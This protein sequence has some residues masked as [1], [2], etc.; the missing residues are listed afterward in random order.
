[1]KPDVELV[2]RLNY[3]VSIDKN[4]VTVNIKTSPLSDILIGYMSDCLLEKF[5]DLGT[6]VYDHT[7]LKSQDHVSIL[8]SDNP[9]ACYKF[10]LFCGN[11]TE[12]LLKPSFVQTQDFILRIKYFSKKPQLPLT[13]IVKKLQKL[14]AKKS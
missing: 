8:Y 10:L 4:E 12:R 7:D 2:D 6:V 11:R 14:G 5:S 13:K 1:M 3:K 9:C